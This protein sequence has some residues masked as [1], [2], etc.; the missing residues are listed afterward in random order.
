MFAYSDR[1]DGAGE[2]LTLERGED[3]RCGQAAHSGVGTSVTLPWAE[4]RT[5]VRGGGGLL[6]FGSIGGPLGQTLPEGINQYAENCGPDEQVIGN[7]VINHVA[8][9]SFVAASGPRV[10]LAH[11]VSQVT[12][13]LPR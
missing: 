6:R 3:L 9:G 5:C 1:F 4:A 11:R 13:L 12:T 7:W 2:M 8:S 10:L